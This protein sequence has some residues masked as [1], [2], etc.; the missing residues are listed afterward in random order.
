MAKVT[1]Q[2]IASELRI[3]YKRQCQI[4]TT[5]RDTQYVR[6]RYPWRV[7]ISQEGGRAVSASQL[8]QRNKFKLVKSKYAT[9][10]ASDKTRWKDANPEWHSYL[11]GYNFFMLEG[12]LGGGLPTY[13]QM[14]KSIQVVKEE[15]PTS[16]T[17]S[18]TISAVDAAKCVVLIQGNSFIS[19]TIQRFSG[20]AADNTEVTKSLSPNVDPV[21]TEVK[22]YGD[23]GHSEMF[24]SEGEGSGEGHWGSWV[25]SYLSASQVKAKLQ[26]LFSTQ[27]FAYYIEVIEHKA[28]TIYPVL[29]SIAAE[30]VVI[31]W[32][33][34]PSVAADVSITVVEYI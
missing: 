18:F 13:P 2:N 15:V 31:D 10:S 24:I 33:K 29:V 22:V 19:D 4:S 30:V 34:V 17:K 16:G 11:F 20:V 8:T 21:I 5:S 9:L 6:S 26:Q 27:Q 7:P 1:G 28:Q 23:G 25:C 3:A 14:I 32:A 12:L